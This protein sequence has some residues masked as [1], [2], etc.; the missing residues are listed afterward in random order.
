MS[1]I[2]NPFKPKGDFFLCWF[3]LLVPTCFLLEKY[4]FAS[5]WYSRL[6]LAIGASLLFVFLL[7]GPVLLFKQVKSSGTRGVLVFHAFLSS[8]GL[9]A[10]AVIIIYSM[11]L[12]SR[13]ET[14]ARLT[15]LGTSAIANFYLIWKARRDN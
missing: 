14:W 2:D 3:L 10:I 5:E 8:L 11:D 13:N 1:E 12:Q 15:I 9:V 6:A 7:Y 4:D